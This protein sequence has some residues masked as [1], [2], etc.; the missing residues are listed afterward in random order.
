MKNNLKKN[1]FILISIMVLWIIISFFVVQPQYLKKL[2]SSISNLVINDNVVIIGRNN[3]KNKL[4]EKTGVTSIRIYSNGTE[5]GNTVKI[6]TGDVLRDNSNEYSIA[7]LGDVN[8]DGI[9]DLSDAS[10]TY[11]IFKNLVTPTKVERMSADSTKDNIINISDVSRTYRIF[12]NL[13]PDDDSSTPTTP[14]VTKYTVTFNSNGGST[15][16]SITKNNGDTIGTL[17]TPTRTGYTFNGWYTAKTGGSKINSAT[18]VTGNVTYYA[19]WTINKHTVTFNSNGGSA[20]SSITK[21]Y[22]DTI[23]TLPTSSRTGYTLNGWYTAKTGGSK[24]STSAKVTGNVTYYAQ[25]TAV[26]YTATFNSNG[27]SA[28]GSIQ[29]AYGEKLGTLPTTTKKCNSF[30]GWYYKESASKPFFENN[31]ISAN[32]TMPNNNVTY[33]ARWD[34]NVEREGNYCCSCDTS[35]GMKKFNDGKY[36]YVVNKT[37]QTGWIQYSGSWYY[38]DSTGTLKTGWQI[39]DGKSYYF[40]SDGVMQK[41]CFIDGYWLTDSGAWDNGPKSS[42]YKG[43]NGKWWYGYQDQSWYAKSNTY[44]IDGK[45]YTFDYYGYC[46]SGC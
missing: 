13:V 27:G 5:I 29:R 18:K 1:Y 30:G 12:K 21:N 38:A 6:K 10:R 25:W 24:I 19:Q 42:W 32:T 2:V 17:P 36:R 11:R 7:V 4:I 44:R 46:A 28:V 31:K 35:T 20:V 14:S 39:I 9:V 41:N 22:G 43:T 16:S 15:V 33:Y 40:N 45:N 8:K 34:N 23:G 3:T 26:K 37:I